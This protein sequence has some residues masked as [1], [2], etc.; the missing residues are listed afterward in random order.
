MI[1]NTEKAYQQEG[2][3]TCGALL[4]FLADEEHKIFKGNWKC[5]IKAPNLLWHI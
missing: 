4:Y 5:D 2:L 3:Q 1:A